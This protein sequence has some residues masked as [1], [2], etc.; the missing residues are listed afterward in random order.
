M[1]KRQAL[2]LGAIVGCI[3]L[4]KWIP[5]PEQQE[6]NVKGHFHGIYKMMLDGLM[7]IAPIILIF[8]SMGFA[9]VISE[10]RGYEILLDLVMKVNLNPTITFAI[11]MLS[12]I[13]I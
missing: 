12:L 6:S 7:S 9:S 2:A 5:I 3:I 10:T 4:Y 13:H 8:L 11:I 1:Y